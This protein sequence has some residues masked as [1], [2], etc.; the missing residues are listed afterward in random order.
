MIILFFGFDPIET[1]RIMPRLVEKLGLDHEKYSAVTLGE[2]VYRYDSTGAFEGKNK[3]IWV[4]GFQK[5]R[6]H[7]YILA[8]LSAELEVPIIM[9]DATVIAGIHGTLY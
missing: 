7:P 4:P 1:D 2:S 8:E 3:A 6:E 5:I 9:T